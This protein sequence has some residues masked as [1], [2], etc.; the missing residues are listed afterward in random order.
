MQDDTSQYDLIQRMKFELRIL[1]NY[2]LGQNHSGFHNVDFNLD[3]IQEML[4]L[5]RKG[6]SDG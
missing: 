5:F 4:N 6:E 3:S 1:E 2:N